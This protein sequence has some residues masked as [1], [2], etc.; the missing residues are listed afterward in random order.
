M[1]G[2]GECFFLMGVGLYG[3]GGGTVLFLCVKGVDLEIY[4][5]FYAVNTVAEFS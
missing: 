5:F 1:V 3:G 2:G 4:C